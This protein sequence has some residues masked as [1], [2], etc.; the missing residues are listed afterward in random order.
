ME[1]K[2]IKGPK[3]RKILRICLRS[4]V[5]FDPKSNILIKISVKLVTSLRLE[6]LAKSHLDE[7]LL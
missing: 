5:N 2:K 3:L 1:K 6:S 7:L 4:F